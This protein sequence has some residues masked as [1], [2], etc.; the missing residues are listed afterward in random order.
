MSSWIEDLRVSPALHVT[1]VTHGTTSLPCVNIGFPS[2]Q[3]VSIGAYGSTLW[4]FPT[5]SCSAPNHL[6][7]AGEWEL[8]LDKLRLPHGARA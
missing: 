7:G 8:L 1:T 3:Q 2:G 5:V 6:V 4:G